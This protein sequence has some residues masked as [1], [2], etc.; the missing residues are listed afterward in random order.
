MFS[1]KV[2]LSKPDRHPFKLV[3]FLNIV[4]DMAD[5][6]S[7]NRD[8]EEKEN[9]SKRSDDSGTTPDHDCSR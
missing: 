7:R 6:L 2:K 8:K 9:T 3:D 1:G 5:E 4:L